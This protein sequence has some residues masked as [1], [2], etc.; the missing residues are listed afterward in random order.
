MSL[1]NYIL[2]QWLLI[3]WS[4][5][6]RSYH[7]NKSPK[8]H[9]LYLLDDT[10][11]TKVKYRQYLQGLLIGIF[12][13]ILLSRNEIKHFPRDIMYVPLQRSSRLIIS[14]RSL[15]ILLSQTRT[16]SW[17]LPS[18]LR[19][20]LLNHIFFPPDFPVSTCPFILCLDDVLLMKIIKFARNL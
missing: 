14:H 10:S 3:V 9:E 4:T 18:A 1:V 16:A 2:L 15:P 20:H 8:V 11:A 5:W 19:L 6:I 17:G 12:N 7:E 13:L